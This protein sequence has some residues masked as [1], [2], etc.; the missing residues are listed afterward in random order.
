MLLTAVAVLA[1]IAI[2]N[3]A[4]LTLADVTFRRVDFAL[5]AALGGSRRRDRRAGDCPGAGAGGDRRYRRA[6]DRG[7]AASGAAGP[8][9]VQRLRRRAAHHR[10]ASR[11]RRAGGGAGGDADGGGGA[12]HP[13]RRPRP[14][15]GSVRRWPPD[16]RRAGGAAIPDHPRVGTD[17]TRGRA[18]VHRRIGDDDAV[19][20]HPAQSRFRCHQCGGRAAQAVGH[21][22]ADEWPAGPRSC[23]RCWTGSPRRPA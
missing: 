1:L 6:D 15:V 17:G 4:N 5:R 7:L 13:L 12:G 20:D 3:L 9:S 19:P 22:L 18:P 16:H 11:R 2:A 10:L 23:S 14:R 21:G 8:R